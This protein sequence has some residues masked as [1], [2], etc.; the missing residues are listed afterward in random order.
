MVAP[1]LELTSAQEPALVQLLCCVVAGARNG[2]EALQAVCSAAVVCRSL[3]AASADDAG[4]WQALALGLWPDVRAL[5][6][7]PP[8][9]FRAF[10][11]ARILAQRRFETRGWQERAL[12][13][14][15][16]FVDVQDAAVLHAAP[17]ASLALPMNPEALVWQPWRPNAP[18]INLCDQALPAP[19]ATWP[20]SVRLRLLVLRSDGAVAVLVHCL[21]RRSAPVWPDVSYEAGQALMYNTESNGERMQATFTLHAEG[22]ELSLH[23]WGFCEEHDGDGQLNPA[24]FIQALQ[25]LLWMPKH[26]LPRYRPL[27]CVPVN[28]CGA[29]AAV[30]SQP[31]LLAAV[32]SCLP[33]RDLAASALTCV[34]FAAAARAD[35]TWRIAVQRHEAPALAAHLA[36]HLAAQA[37]G[38][39]PPLCRRAVGT[40]L[41]AVQLRTAVH[42]RL[43]SRGETRFQARYSRRGRHQAAEE[44]EESSGDDDDTARSH[45]RERGMDCV[46]V[47]PPPQR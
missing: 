20:Q 34:A 37:A 3:R 38:A 14:F 21:A 15:L 23:V 45:E 1:V 43:M 36:A 8:R 33:L 10:V 25:Q 27:H 41:E 39:A 31:P 19:V 32:L 44:P 35:D 30:L 11:R 9:G 5:D 24:E 22:A 6:A 13:D 47:G 18:D 17:L 12:S 42:A 46:P 16:L 40:Q 29:V 7:P 4:V 28:A 2:T 26:E